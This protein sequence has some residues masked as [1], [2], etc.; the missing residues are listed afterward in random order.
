MADPDPL[1]PSW[2]PPSPNSVL[3]LS[4][5]LGLDPYSGLFAG[6]SP[7]QLQAYNF[8]TDPIFQYTFGPGGPLPSGPA[9][10]YPGL[11]PP[12]APDPFAQLGEEQGA[13]SAFGAR[14]LP[15]TGNV[16]WASH[17]TIR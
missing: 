9:N 15:E 4:G 3:R 6:L 2:S 12:S 17:S 5:Q 10:P 14:L 16:E 8:L 11:F 7:E 13:P 1:A